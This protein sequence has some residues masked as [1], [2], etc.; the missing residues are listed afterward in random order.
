MKGVIQELRSE[1][2]KVSNRV[3]H[4]WKALRRQTLDVFLPVHQHFWSSLEF[5]M[6]ETKK[7]YHQW[8]K[9]KHYIYQS[10]QIGLQKTGL[11]STINSKTITWISLMV[12][13]ISYYIVN[14][15]W[16]F[17][18]AVQMSSLKNKQN[19]CIRR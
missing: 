19:Q 7:N 1:V 10:K 16:I 6:H 12:S 5:I 13:E 4:V 14:L 2:K 17:F 3:Y 15:E 18:P 8:R 9:R 11:E